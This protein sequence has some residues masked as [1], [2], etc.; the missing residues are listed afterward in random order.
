M[1]LDAIFAWPRISTLAGNRRDAHGGAGLSDAADA[2]R[3]AAK[4]LGEGRLL[5][6]TS[7]ETGQ[8]VR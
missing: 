2:N 7:I 5:P 8:L 6:S 3:E 1:R 4:W